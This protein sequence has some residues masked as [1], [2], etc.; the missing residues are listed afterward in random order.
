[1]VDQ[2]FSVRVGGT[3]GGSIDPTGHPE[4]TGT[5]QELQGTLLGE[6]GPRSEIQIAGEMSAGDH[7]S[8]VPEE[9][10]PTEAPEVNG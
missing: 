5:D 4:Q 9:T 2:T 10:R 3:V 6:R 8:I 1:M 7:A